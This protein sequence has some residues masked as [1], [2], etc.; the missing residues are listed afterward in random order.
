LND[1]NEV[2]FY[3][4]GDGGQTWDKVKRSL[5]ATGYNHNVFHQFLSLRAGLYVFGEG[6]VRFD[7]FVYNPL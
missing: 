5:D 2:S 6:R 7:N 3:F 1:H 4:S